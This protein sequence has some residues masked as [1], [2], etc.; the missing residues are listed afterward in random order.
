VR[1]RRLA[2]AFL[3][4]LPA[5]FGAAMLLA[6]CGAPASSTVGSGTAWVSQPAATPDLS[7]PAGVIAIGHSGLTAEGTV[8]PGQPAKDNSWATGTNADVNSVYLR[9]AAVRP[10]TKDQ[11]ANTAQGGASSETLAGQA[12]SALDRVPV[13]ALAIIQSIDNDIRCDGTDAENIKP[14]GENIRA[15]LD[16]IRKASPNT[17]ILVVGQLGRPSAAY[18][19]ELVARE[20]SQ[21]DALTGTGPCDFFNESGELVLANLQTLTSIINSYEQEQARVCAQFPNCH[22]DGGVRAKYIDKIENYLPDFNHLNVAGQ[23][24]EAALIWPVVEKILQP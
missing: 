12:M 16:A 15:A 5:V 18:L 11:T 22:T 4:V 20:S 1:T 9:L 13:P 7:K 2:S 8:E 10:E 6:G 23:A 3:K 19:S 24:A 14:F 21:K 17:Q